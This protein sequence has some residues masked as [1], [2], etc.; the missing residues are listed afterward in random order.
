M[1]RKRKNIFVPSE[2][3]RK[4]SN[5][6]AWN[7]ELMNKRSGVVLWLPRKQV[8]KMLW[9]EPEGRSRWPQRAGETRC[10]SSRADGRYPGTWYRVIAWNGIVGSCGVLCRIKCLP[11]FW[12]PRNPGVK[13]CEINL[14]HLIRPPRN[15]WGLYA[16]CPSKVWH[17]H[18]TIFSV[19]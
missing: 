1:I 12:I 13:I 8:T 16:F 3:W 17:N 14:F 4:F 15:R 11:R 6:C 18:H 5:I 10:P 2:L 9:E 19:N 7:E